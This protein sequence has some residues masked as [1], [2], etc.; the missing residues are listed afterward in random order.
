M[1]VCF[2]SLT[3]ELVQEDEGGDVAGQ[4]EELADYHE[5][6]PRL[7]GQGHHQ[8][9]SQD[10]RGEGNGDDVEELWLEEQQRPVHDDAPC[11]VK[12]EHRL[13]MR[14]TLQRHS[15]CLVW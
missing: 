7:D 1:Y 13:R 15:R 11:G 5:P 2:F 4:A 10:E 8:K 3:Y 9:L 14:P 6:V 12:G